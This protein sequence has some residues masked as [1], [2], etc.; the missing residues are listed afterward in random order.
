MTDNRNN[1]PG[2]RMRKIVYD[3]EEDSPIARLPRATSQPPVS[4]PPASP[5][6]VSA[7]AEPPQSTPKTDSP[8]KTWAFGSFGP[9]FL[10]VTG[11]LSLIVN[12]VLI[13][14]L[15]TVLPLLGSLQFNPMAIGSDLLGG[16]YTNFEKMETAHIVTSVPVNLYDVP[17]DFVLDY[18]TDTEVILTAD[19]TILANVSI[20]SGIISING[21]ATIILRKD[22]RL[23]VHLDLQIPVNTTVNIENKELPIDIP[24]ATTSQG[25]NDAFVCLKEVVRPYYCMVDPNAVNLE[26]KSVCKKK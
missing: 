23:P 3:S 10:T 24:L 5:P 12:A 8:K 1:E 6:P 18:S 9:P 26:Q 7:Q 22:T 11:C 13:A 19:T 21:P 2:N 14:V 25:L 4:Q 16:L 17:V 20:T 15:L